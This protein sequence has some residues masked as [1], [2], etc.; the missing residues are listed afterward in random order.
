MITKIITIM[1]R[2]ITLIYLIALTFISTYLQ[3]QVLVDSTGNGSFVDLGSSAA[4]S[5]SNAINHIQINSGGSVTID[6][7][8]G[9]SQYYTIEVNTGGH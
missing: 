7:N 6:G 2:R 5:G 1:K 4:F 9:N 3:A 8:G